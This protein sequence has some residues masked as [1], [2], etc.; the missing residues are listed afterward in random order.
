M[1]VPEEF[2]LFFDKL[3]QDSDIVYGPTLDRIIRGILAGMN[4]EQIIVLRL[5]LVEAVRSSLSDE[6][7][8]RLY[9]QTNA[10]LRPQEF[11]G[12]RDFFREIIHY[13]DLDRSRA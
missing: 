13:I 11:R 7:L 1:K 2:Y 8:E 12:F 9:A 3:Y 5:F 10:E 6:D 4:S